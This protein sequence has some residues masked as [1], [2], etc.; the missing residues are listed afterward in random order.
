MLDAEVTPLINGDNGSRDLYLVEGANSNDI[1]N[2]AWYHIYRTVDHDTA[3]AVAR[4]HTKVY[5]RVIITIMRKGEVPYMECQG[6]K[7]W[8]W[9]TNVG[10]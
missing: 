1:E 4:D 3:V 6:N 8:K 2:P 9:P 5:K 10:R 7:E